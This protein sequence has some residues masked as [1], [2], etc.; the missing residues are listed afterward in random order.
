MSHDPRPSP[1]VSYYTI[2]L[3]CYRLDTALTLLAEQDP[4]P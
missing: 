4:T 2:C 3:V 1:S